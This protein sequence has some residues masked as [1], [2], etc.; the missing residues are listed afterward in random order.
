[1]NK[2]AILFVLLIILGVGIEAVLLFKLFSFPKSINFNP[3][4]NTI[5]Q[6]TVK[7]VAPIGGAVIMVKLTNSGFEPRSITANLGDKVIWTNSTT[8]DAAVNSA[9]HPT[10]TLY[11]FLNLGNFVP[12]QTVRVILR[13]KGTFTYHNH[14]SPSQTGTITVK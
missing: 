13:E 4:Q 6:Q 3:K 1:M 10:H 5:Q 14:L 7:N 12:N 11:P 2:L 8:S 9:N